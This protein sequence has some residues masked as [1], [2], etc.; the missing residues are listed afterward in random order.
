M[1]HAR[2]PVRISGPDL[3]DFKPVFAPVPGLK[4]GALVSDGMWA[5]LLGADAEHPHISDIPD[6][7]FASPFH[8]S[9]LSA[10]HG[11]TV[12][13]GEHGG[14]KLSETGKGFSRDLA[15]FGGRS[16]L[17]LEQGTL[18]LVE[19]M[20]GQSNRLIELDAEVSQEIGVERLQ[21]G[22]APDQGQQNSVFAFSH[23]IL[24][25]LIARIRALFTG[26]VE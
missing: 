19:N 26:G 6:S 23:L 22:H 21:H 18:G 5:A 24:R 9:A 11:D 17:M 7:V 4:P 25:G 12:D 10:G 13:H 16:A 15:L 14:G 3:I 8:C 2:R 1:S 20:S